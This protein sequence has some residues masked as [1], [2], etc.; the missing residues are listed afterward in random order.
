MIEI[1]RFVF[2]HRG[3]VGRPPKNR[4]A[5][6]KAVYNISDTKALIDRLKSDKNLR[7]V[8]GF[9][10]IYSIPADLHFHEHFK[11]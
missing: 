6:A 2:D 1:E 10:T 5:I 8:C 3:Y 11:P 4:S 7:K 9:E